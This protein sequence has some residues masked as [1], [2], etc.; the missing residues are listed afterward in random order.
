MDQIADEERR[1]IAEL[2]AEGAP[3]WKLHQEISR[4]RHAIRRA[5][6]A[7]HR[8]GR[9][10]PN[11]S[12][13]RLSLAEREEI[14]RGLAAGGS[15]SA[16]ALT[17]ACSTGR[18]GPPPPSAARA[19]LGATTPDLGTGQLFAVQ[20]VGQLMQRQHGDRLPVLTASSPLDRLSPAPGSR[21]TRQ[22]PRNT[23]RRPTEQPHTIHQDRSCRTRCWPASSPARQ[24]P[25]PNP[26]SG[27]QGR[28]HP[29]IPPPSPCCGWTRLACFVNQ[30]AT[31]RRDTARSATSR[32]PPGPAPLPT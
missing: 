10:E 31:R 20:L 24:S 19:L 17:A 18:S 1:R 6:V 2:V 28:K 30:G 26:A 27:L 22:H 7:L 14:S 15:D 13:L 4:S 16:R 32:R 8:P 3:P 23:H 9:R 29:S 25:R 11:R 12:P 5:V 21:T